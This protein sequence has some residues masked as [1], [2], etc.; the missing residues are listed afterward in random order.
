MSAIPASEAGSAVPRQTRTAPHLGRLL[1]LV[2]LTAVAAIALWYGFAQGNNPLPTLPN[3]SQ[4]LWLV[5][6]G[7]AA[8]AVAARLTAAA[9][10]RPARW[11]AAVRRLNAVPL[12]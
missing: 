4:L 7:F 10:T 11:A 2:G 8:S 6:I 12:V 1:A 9:E 3:G 5:V